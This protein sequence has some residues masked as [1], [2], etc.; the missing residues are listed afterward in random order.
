MEKLQIIYIVNE[1]HLEVFWQEKIYFI[2]W[3]IL[4]GVLRL[5]IATEMI[6]R[7]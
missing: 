2:T 6:I 1:W 4:R 5:L 7:F 3:L